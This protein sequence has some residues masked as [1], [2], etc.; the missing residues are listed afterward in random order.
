MHKKISKRECESEDAIL[1]NISNTRL[2]AWPPSAF[3]KRAKMGPDA[4][5][6]PAEI[7]PLD[8]HDSLA[9]HR[10]DCGDGRRLSSDPADLDTL[11]R[12]R[13]STEIS[14]E[15]NR[16]T[17]DHGSTPVISVWKRVAGMEMDFPEESPTVIALPLWLPHLNGLECASERLL[18]NLHSFLP[19]R[20]RPPTR[21]L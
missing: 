18:N 20:E 10:T 8:V 6:A 4:G 5:L 21:P 3:V 9:G 12:T 19:R 16:K 15:L 14:R 7:W 13:V 17:S 11:G 1:N 2:F